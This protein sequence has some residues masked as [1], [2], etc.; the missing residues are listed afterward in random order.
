MAN[1]WWMFGEGKL[2]YGT[3]C[4]ICS[5]IVFDDKIQSTYAGGISYKEFLESLTKPM[6]IQK[7]NDNYLYYFYGV[8]NLNSLF[9]LDKYSAWQTDYTIDKKIS[10]QGKFIV[11]TQSSKQL[12]KPV[13]HTAPQFPFKLEQISI[14]GCGGNFLTKGT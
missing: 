2:D 4:A 9:V 8:N 10:L 1:C 12:L 7:S 13:E 14:L 6:N 3:G 5:Y 11:M